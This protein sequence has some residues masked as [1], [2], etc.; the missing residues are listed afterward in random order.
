MVAAA[1]GDATRQSQFSRQVKELEAALE[2]KLFKKVGKTLELTD[3][4]RQLALTTQ[5]FFRSLNE[6]SSSPEKRE[7][8]VIGGSESVLRWSVL[9]R[10]AGIIAG[11][12]RLTLELRS[13]RTEE[14]LRALRDG[15]TDVVVVRADAVE[16]TDAVLAAGSLAYRL[17]VARRLLPGKSAAGIRLMRTIPFAILSG[18]GQLVRQIHQF[19]REAG[20]EMDIRLR[21]EN[22]TLLLEALD[23]WDL[24][25]LL[26]TPAIEQ[27]SKERY[28][29]IVPPQGPELRR[30][31]AVIYEP[32]AAEF[33]GI[34]KKTAQRLSRLLREAISEGLEGEIVQEKH[35]L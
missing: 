21:V 18:E 30:E 10:L 28:A 8:V 3:A 26:P 34:I 16:R 23:H 19:S 27:L 20:W 29:V 15:A 24:A 7:A 4:G 31:L 14:A 13:F 32:K 9:P 2:T 17:V 6:I 25:A 35:P 5:A 11:P 1:K 33:R 12:E 22:F